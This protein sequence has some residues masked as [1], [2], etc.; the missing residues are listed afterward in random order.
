MT[1]FG[2]FLKDGYNDTSEFFTNLVCG[3]SPDFSKGSK[4]I[5]ASPTA[6]RDPSESIDA[7]RRLTS[8]GRDKLEV[9]D[10]ED[11]TRR[12]RPSNLRERCERIE[13]HKKRIESENSALRSWASV[14]GLQSDHHQAMTKEQADILQSQREQMTAQ[15]QLISQQ[16]E[17]ILKLR[18]DNEKAK[19]T[20]EERSK[21]TQ[22]KIDTLQAELDRQ[23]AESKSLSNQMELERNETRRHIKRLR[24]QQKKA[25]NVLNS[26][27]SLFWAED[28]DDNDSCASSRHPETRKGKPM[29]VTLESTQEDRA[30]DEELSESQAPPN[31]D[32]L[33]KVFNWT[34]GE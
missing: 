28:V 16:K 17:E 3:P 25:H 10:V 4:N 5:T 24:R 9:I 20:L 8:D 23:S 26:G 22:S 14:V 31:S 33:D 21:E 11:L 15:L 12:K 29:E 6:T 32:L 13:E 30:A 2:D 1:S 18:I 19:A 27:G 34:V 7:Q